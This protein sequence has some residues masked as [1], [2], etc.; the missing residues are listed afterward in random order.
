VSATN[1]ARA[2]VAGRALERDGEMQWIE[3]LMEATG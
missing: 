2:I 1:A 3:R